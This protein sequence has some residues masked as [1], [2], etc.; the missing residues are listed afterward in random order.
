MFRSQIAVAKAPTGAYGI[1]HTHTNT[2]LKDRI[3]SMSLFIPERVPELFML[4]T[5]I[6]QE[7][8]LCLH[9]TKVA[10]MGKYWKMR[11]GLRYIELFMHM[12]K[13]YPESHQKAWIVKEHHDKLQVRQGDQPW[14][15]I[16]DRSFVAHGGS[17]M[18]CAPACK[19][20]T[21]TKNWTCDKS[22]SEQGLPPHTKAVCRE[23]ISSVA[24]GNGDLEKTGPANSKM[25]PWRKSEKRIRNALQKWANIEA[26]NVMTKMHVHED[27]GAKR[28]AAIF[29][30]AGWVLDR[31]Q[32]GKNLSVHIRRPAASSYWKSNWSDTCI[33]ELNEP[34]FSIHSFWVGVTPACKLGTETKNWTCD[35][36]PSEQG[37]PPHTKAVC[38]E[39]I[40]SVAF[41]NGDLEKTGP[42]N[43]KMIPW[44]KSE[45]RIRNA[46][47]E[48]ANIEARNVMTKMHVHEDIGAKRTAAIFTCAGWVLDRR[49]VG[50]NLS[51]HIRRPAASSYWKSNW[52]DTCI[53]GL[54]EPGFSIHSSESEWSRRDAISNL[55]NV[56]LKISTVRLSTYYSN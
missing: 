9:W 54:N 12:T 41:S 33:F 21:E 5:C 56:R 26:R 51:V 27:I 48:W 19:L 14:Y 8:R 35:K 37:L 3:S 1:Q 13:Q 24:F 45:K 4:L 44:R 20:G 50:K 30:C 2:H 7:G 40:S 42:A 46:L 29:T 15:P 32:V 39:N 36:S 11:N 22:P 52:S 16:Q 34:G 28:T 10:E 31:R 49:Q 43:S 23:N 25:I 6:V 47:Q 53:F 17:R 18:P 55:T 38:R